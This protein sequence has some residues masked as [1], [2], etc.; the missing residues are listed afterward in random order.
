MLTRNDDGHQTGVDQEQI[1]AV[2][3]FHVGEHSSSVVAHSTVHVTH[4]EGYGQMDGDP[5]QQVSLKCFPTT[6]TEL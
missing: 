1:G 2:H 5:Q 6:V 3:E 4:Y